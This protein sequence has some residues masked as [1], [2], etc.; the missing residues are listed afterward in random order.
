MNVQ[1]QDSFFKS[2]KRLMWQESRPYKFYSL[3]RHKIPEFLKNVWRFR[4][5]LWSH[6]WWDYRFTLEILKRSLEIQYLGMKT[7]GYEERVSLEKKLV[8]MARAIEILDNQIKEDYLSIVEEK[9]GKL[10]DRE[11]K[12]E[13]TEDGNYVL[14]DDETDEEKKHN[15]M[16]FKKSWDLKEAEWKELWK[17]IQGKKWKDY[18]DYDGSDLR[19]WWD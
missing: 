4:R 18:K 9:Y 6:R 5:E 7:K 17:I 1:F 3:F 19:G 8:A 2:L 12:F 11:W 14:V 13:E 10:S 15:S 16:L